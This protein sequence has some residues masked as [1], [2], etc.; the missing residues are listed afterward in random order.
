MNTTQQEARKA[1]KVLHFSNWSGFATTAC[2]K[3]LHGWQGKATPVA[4]DRVRE[5]SC[6][7]CLAALQA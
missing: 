6:K 3:S 2:G 4:T 1:R 7:R 5:V